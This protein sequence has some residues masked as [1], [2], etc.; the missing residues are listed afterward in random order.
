M[1]GFGFRFGNLYD[2]DFTHCFAILQNVVHSLELGETP[3]NSASHQAQNYVQRKYHKTFNRF[4][5]VAVRFRLLF[6]FTVTHS[7]HSIALSYRV[8]EMSAL[9]GTFLSH[10][11]Q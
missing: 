8:G 1:Y 7:Y 11:R 4:G 3:N 2:I 5:T 6:Q 10:C 9:I